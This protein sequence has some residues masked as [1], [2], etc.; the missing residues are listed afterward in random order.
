MVLLLQTDIRL[1]LQHQSMV[2][3]FRND[4][5][6]TSYTWWWSLLIIFFPLFFSLYRLFAPPALTRSPRSV[7]FWT[8]SPVRRFSLETVVVAVHPPP[9]PLR[10]PLASPVGRPF[11]VAMTAAAP[12]LVEW[13]AILDSTLL[14]LLRPAWPPQL[15]NHRRCRRPRPP[16]LA[17]R[18]FTWALPLPPPVQRPR[19]ESEERKE[20][21]A[22]VFSFSLYQSH[23]SQL[24][25]V[26]DLTILHLLIL[27]A[28][29]VPLFR[30][31]LF[32]VC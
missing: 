28:F 2:W 9:L 14:R 29:S 3:D 22:A 12:P 6:W 31:S 21:G 7:P 23:T 30:F 17:I 16:P 1:W 27:C 10:A 4:W 26:F 19:V 18:P 24:F 8:W 20:R 13:W 25:L 5:F 32:S 15:L 11:T